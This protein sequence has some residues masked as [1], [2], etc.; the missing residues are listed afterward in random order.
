MPR[1]YPEFFQD[2]NVVWR[3]TFFS[4]SAQLTAVDP[5][6]VTFKIKSPSGVTTTPS[7]TNEAGTGNFSSS[8][9]VNEYG[10][11][12]WRWETTGPVIVDQGTINV[13]QRNVD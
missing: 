11:W 7:V 3:K 10:L 9:V 6:T 12:N 13:L 5:S 2:E 4:D 8:K 1:L